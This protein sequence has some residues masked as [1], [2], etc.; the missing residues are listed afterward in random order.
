[1]NIAAIPAAPTAEDLMEFWQRAMPIGQAYY[2]LDRSEVSQKYQSYFPRTFGLNV[3]TC[4]ISEALGKLEAIDKRWRI[5]TSEV[6]AFH[7]LGNQLR[8]ALVARVLDDELTLIGFVNPRGIADCPKCVPKD[9]V[10]RGIDWDNGRVQGQGLRIDEVRVFPV[11]WIRR[12]LR[13]RATE[14]AAIEAPKRG[15]PTK[16]DTI[17]AA[18]DACLASNL[19]DLEAS[20]LVAATMV[21]N[22]IKAHAPDDFGDGRGL[23]LD[24]IRRTISQRFDAL[25]HA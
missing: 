6:A 13:S 5:S 4:G 15:R 3:I 11:E 24:I 21:Q 12:R 8:K 1:M 17:T 14:I 22:W 2:R 10:A 20:K 18:F 16:R 23:G 19:I 9:L 25:R 7:D